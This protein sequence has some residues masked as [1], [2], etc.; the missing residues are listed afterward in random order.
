MSFS[1]SE[2]ASTS[3]CWSLGLFAADGVPK[4]STSGTSVA[5]HSE[6][7]SLSSSSPFCPAKNPFRYLCI[8][9][10]AAEIIA[11]ASAGSFLKAGRTQ[12]VEG[13][14]LSKSTGSLDKA[15]EIEASGV[16]LVLRSRRPDFFK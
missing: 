2:Q 16:L 6:S 12:Y 8:F 7:S 9:S 4:S 10:L 13:A 3:L 15:T 1:F 11:S 5:S 14:I